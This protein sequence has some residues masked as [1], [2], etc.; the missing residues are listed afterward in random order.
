MKDNVQN[1]VETHEYVET[2][3]RDSEPHI[4]DVILDFSTPM[5]DELDEHYSPPEYSFEELDYVDQ[6][7]TKNQQEEGVETL[8]KNQKKKINRRIRIRDARKRDRIEQVCE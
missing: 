5:C 3:L 8:T 6:F 1:N 7:Q 2:T 4:D